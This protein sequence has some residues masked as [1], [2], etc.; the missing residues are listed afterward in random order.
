MDE[1]N[2]ILIKNNLLIEEVT[3]FFYYLCVINT[4]IRFE[5]GKKS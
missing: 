1:L 3:S 4:R 5:T 2:K